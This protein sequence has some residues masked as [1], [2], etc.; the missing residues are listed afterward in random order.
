MTKTIVL[1]GGGALLD[2]LDKLLEKEIK[3]VRIFG[4]EGKFENNILTVTLEEEKYMAR[5]FEILLK[6]NC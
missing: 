6:P 2:G 1:T 3:D 4:A 5:Y